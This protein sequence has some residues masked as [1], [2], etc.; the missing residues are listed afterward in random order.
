[1][2]NLQLG[3]DYL[4]HQFKAKTRHGVHSPFAYRLVDEVIYD[5]RA[6]PEYNKIEQLRRDLLQDERWISITD[7]GAGSHVNNNKR[8]QVKALAKNALKSA[9]LAQLIHRLAA[10]IKPRNIIELGTCLGITTA[11]L[12]K[13]APEAKVISIEG[14]P[15]TA[16]V[17][18]ENLS[19]LDIRNT[20][21]LVGNF[22]ELLP[23]VI[24]DLP[25]LD[26]VFID[27]NHRKEATL[28]YFKWCLPRLGA[29]SIMIFDDIYWS[30]GMKEAWQQIKDHPEV[31]VTIDLFWIGLAFVR[32]G[33]AKE[34]F[35][36]R[37]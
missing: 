20:D 22:D 15:E 4:K 36:I 28:N 14:C 10:E 24:S 6:K 34:D 12:A 29:N 7:L 19:K 5:F 26:F 27:G 33:Q 30:N 3:L 31:D 35:K 16:S 18:Q 8:K 1:M 32:K 2:I 25:E 21:L 11:Y 13:A 23:F 17:A 37:F 9:K